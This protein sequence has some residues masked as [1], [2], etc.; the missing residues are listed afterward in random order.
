MIIGR[1]VDVR[2][3]APG[4]IGSLIYSLHKIN[5]I[6]P[7]SIDLRGHIDRICI[8]YLLNEDVMTH[9]AFK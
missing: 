8:D 6:E 3:L 5:F 7:E 2:P 9:K 4:T 1:L